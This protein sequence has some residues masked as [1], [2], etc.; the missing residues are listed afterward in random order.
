M[1]STNA[2]LGLAPLADTPLTFYLARSTSALYALHGTI[3]L[4]ASTDPPRYRTLI[5]VL[6]GGNVAFGAALLG[7][8]TS[9]GMPS[10]WTFGEGPFVFVVGVLLLVLSRQV[11]N[12]P[13]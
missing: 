2:W 11:G 1:V 8:D 10:W 6:G 9:A 5:Q 7:I 13:R 3:L 12:E 4:L